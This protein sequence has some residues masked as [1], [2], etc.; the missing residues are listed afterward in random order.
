MASSTLFGKRLG[1][2]RKDEDVRVAEFRGDVVAVPGELDDVGDAAIPRQRFERRAARTAADDPIPQAG[3]SCLQERGRA[4]QRFVVLL[5]AQ[6]GDADHAPDRVA[7]GTIGIARAVET[8]RDDR[9]ARRLEP[10]AGEHRGGGRR[11]R[12]DTG[13]TAIGEPLQPDLAVRLVGIQLAPAADADRAP[14]RAAAA[15]RPNTFE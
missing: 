3:T 14:R 8:V 12:D 9:D 15:G 13:R 5:G 1:T 10:L 4:D 2:R 7:P 11:V 6:V